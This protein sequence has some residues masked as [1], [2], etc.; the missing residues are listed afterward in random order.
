M[1][2]TLRKTIE[3]ISVSNTAADLWDELYL[4]GAP[5]VILS[6]RD[7][8]SY[9]MRLLGPFVYGSRIFLSPHLKLKKI[10]SSVEMNKIL[11]SDD[12]AF[13]AVRTKVFNMVP[14][15]AR[16]KLHVE[17]INDIKLHS[18]K[19]KAYVEI[20]TLVN[21]LMYK[22]QWQPVVFS[23][24]I[25]LDSNAKFRYENPSIIC[26]NKGL[27]NKVL[28]DVLKKSKDQKVVVNT[29]ISGLLAHDITISRQG[30]GID[31]K[32]VVK[33]SDDS[34]ELNKSVISGVLKKGL[35][36]IRGIA[37]STNKKSITENRSGYL[38]RVSK[39]YSMGASL[40]GEI[41]N[42][43][44]LIDDNDYI[45][46]VEESIS[47]LPTEAFE[48]STVGNTIGSLEI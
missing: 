32:Y 22:T 13:Q 34:F 37:K 1:N 43:A 28:E 25:I 14:D 24:A 19:G 9:K 38:Y 46:D 17:S 36:D 31:S 5:Q 23:N 47:E 30:T 41:Y 26:L 7:G 20:I 35:W 42:Q 3:E 15:E 2:A 4:N 29:N 16:K 10:M 33:V 40:M 48:G 11:Q 8:T 45:E 18:A 39:D 12:E 21:S 6:F 27:C 44:Q